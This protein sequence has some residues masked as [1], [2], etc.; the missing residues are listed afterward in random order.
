VQSPLRPTHPRPQSSC[1]QN[2]AGSPDREPQ[3]I[4]ARQTSSDRQ[5]RRL[6]PPANPRTVRFWE[7]SRAVRA[8]N[9]VGDGTVAGERAVVEEAAR[10]PVWS[11][12][13]CVNRTV[14]TL[15]RSRFSSP[16]RRN[17]PG[18]ASTRIR[19]TP[20]TSTMELEPARPNALGPPEP[21][22]TTSSAGFA[23]QPAGWPAIKGGGQDECQR[24]PH[25]FV[26]AFL[27]ELVLK[28]FCSALEP[29]VTTCLQTHLITRVSL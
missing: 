27:I 17:A 29:V 2:R 13:R 15:S 20:P 28:T 19:G 10:S 7:E 26:A 16:I 22:T 9:P 18:P 24:R 23:E 14:S 12:W 11:M 5:T 8:E 25:A 1:A 4:R 6:F 21:S 3:T